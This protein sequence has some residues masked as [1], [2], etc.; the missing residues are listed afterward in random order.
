MT[1]GLKA[2]FFR[3]YLAMTAAYPSTDQQSWSSWITD[4]AVTD[5]TLMDAVLGF[6]A[7]HLRRSAALDDISGSSS[8]I[9]PYAVAVSE[10]SHAYMARAIEA[11]S[12]QIVR[13]GI[14]AQNAPV[15]MATC[16]IIMFHTSANQ[17]FL[18]SSGPEA[19][20]RVPHHW[21]TPF[22]NVN[23]LLKVA[24]PGIRNSRIGHLYKPERQTSSQRN[25]TSGPARS[26]MFD[27]LLEGLDGDD[28]EPETLEAYRIAVDSLDKIQGSALQ[29]DLLRFPAHVP[30]RL[31]ELL[32]MQDPRALAIVGYFFML[33]RR[34]THL[35]WA[36]GA[37]EKEFDGVMSVLPGEWRPKMAWAIE[38]FDWTE[39]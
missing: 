8:C 29:R 14:N 10:A 4:L 20:F 31:V 36:Q 9:N 30:P 28:T 11:H 32:E 37:A 38:E 15:V 16:T 13:E 5:S 2:R 34:A 25:E 6:A 18:D 27:F 1:D 19:G 24:L 22:R 17:S 23:A 33:L 21:F 7:F 3:H 35:W 26:G 39:S 12:R